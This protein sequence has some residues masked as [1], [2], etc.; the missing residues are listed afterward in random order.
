MPKVEI[1]YFFPQPELLKAC[2]LKKSIHCYDLTMSSSGR[3]TT[4]SSSKLTRPWAARAESAN[5]SLCLRYVSI[6]GN[7]VPPLNTTP[8]ERNCIQTEHNPCAS[9]HLLACP[10]WRKSIVCVPRSASGDPISIRVSFYRRVLRLHELKRTTE[11]RST[12]SPSEL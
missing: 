2:E 9:H 1:N 12:T 10:A 4:G 6:S 5:R 7:H 3:R 8:G 11:V